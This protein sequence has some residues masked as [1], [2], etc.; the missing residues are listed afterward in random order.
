M[1]SDERPDRETQ[2]GEDEAERAKQS[3]EPSERRIEPYHY[4]SST[5]MR[6]A[7]GHALSPA[8]P[9]RAKPPVSDETSTAD[10]EPDSNSDSDPNSDSEPNPG[11]DSDSDSD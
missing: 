9:R 5:G 3:A 11:S 7:F 6:R 8:S 2:S 1:S 10:G 4:I